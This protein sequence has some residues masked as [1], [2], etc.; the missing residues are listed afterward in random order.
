ML[1]DYMGCF[2]LVANCWTSSLDVGCRSRS[3]NVARGVIL[4]GTESGTPR[5]QI[6]SGIALDES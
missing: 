5:A 6:V 4:S 1:R 2:N 3:G